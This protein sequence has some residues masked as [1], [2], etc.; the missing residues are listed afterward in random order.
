EYHV[1]HQKFAD[2]LL[3]NGYNPEDV[4][5]MPAS[6]LEKIIEKSP[7][8]GATARDVDWVSKVRLQGRV[9]KWVDH[10]ISVTVNVP[11]NATE[12]LIGEIYRTGWESGC[13]G[14]T[15]YR[16]GSRSGVLV[17]DSEDKAQ[18]KI[19]YSHPPRR[20]QQLEAD[21]VRFNNADQKWI[22]VIGLLD[23]SPYEI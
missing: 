17:S 8:N 13:K 20:P 16:E 4:R 3:L 2:W 12:E 10:S 15:V 21:V 18:P 9:Q 14:I 6:E 11:E 23:G 22:A 1:F 19:E 7:Y 5:D